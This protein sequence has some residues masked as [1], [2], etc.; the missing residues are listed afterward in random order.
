[1][2]KTTFLLVDQ[3]V[4]PSVVPKVIQAKE[5]LRNNQA[6]STAQ[7][8]QTFRQPDYDTGRTLR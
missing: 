4:L 6:S 2:Q 8:A 5:Y 3:D 1:M 7:A